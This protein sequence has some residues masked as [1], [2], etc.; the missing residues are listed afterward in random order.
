M[1]HYEEYFFYEDY[2]QRYHE[3][4]R[5]YV[6]NKFPADLVTFAGEILNRKLQFLRSSSCLSMDA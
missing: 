6:L 3:N 1:C 2:C 5:K 4:T